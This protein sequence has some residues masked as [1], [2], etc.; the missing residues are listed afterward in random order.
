MLARYLDM[1]FDEALASVA[2]ERFGDDLH[3]GCHWLM[4]QGDMGRVHSSHLFES[5]QERSGGL[6][7]GRVR[8]VVRHRD[9][10]GDGWDPGPVHGVEQH[11]HHAGWAL[12]GGVV[13]AEALG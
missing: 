5:S 12:V 8:Q 3:S 11:P 7:V 2:V 10:E 9:P 1:G 6:R 4:M 13:Q